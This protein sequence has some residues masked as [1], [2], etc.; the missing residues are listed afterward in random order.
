MPRPRFLHLA[1]VLFA[2]VLIIGLLAFVH[3][4]T[5]LPQIPTNLDLLGRQAGVRI[6]AD[7]G[8][9]LFT[10]DRRVDEVTLETVSPMFVNAV[11][12]TEDRDFY[13]HHGI[14]VKAILGAVYD[15]VR[16]L[17]RSRGGST[18]TQQIV[19]NLFLSREKTFTRKLKEALLAA[20]LETA[21]REDYGNVAKSRLLELYINGSFFGTN[22]YGVADA[23]RTYFGKSADSLSVREAAMLAG[24]PN[25]PGALSPFRDLEGA[26]RRTDHVLRRMATEGFL[27]QEDLVAAL[28]DSVQLA[29]ERLPRNR[30]PYFVETIK[31]EVARLWGRSAL[32]FGGLNIHTT[33]D[34]GMQ[35]AAEAAVSAGVADLDRR[36]G[37]P[38]YSSAS[39]AAR[40]SYVQSALI[41]LD[42]ATGGVR[43]MVGGRDIFVSYYNR[44]TTARRQPGS[45]FKPIVY[46]A[47]FASGDVTPVSLFVDEPR[48]YGSGRSA[49]RPENF[50][51][52]YLGLTT[53][54]WALINSANATAAQIVDRIGP[55]AVV[56]M[57]R[58]LGI[59]SPLAPYPSIALGSS[60][61]T[62][63][64]LVSA[65]GVIANYGLRVEP[66]FIRSIRALDGDEL[67]RHQA[68]PARM[69]DPEAA[70]T[71][72]RLMQN[73]IERGTGRTVRARGFASPAAGKTGT[74]NDN[75]DAWFTGFTPDLVT[76]VWVGFDTKGKGRKLIEKR[77]R[78][79]I[80]GASGA[81]PIW[82]AFMKSVADK[83]KPF[84]IPDGVSEVMVDPATGI[85]VLT[86]SLVSDSVVVQPIVIALPQGGR[87][88]SRDEVMDFRASLVP[89]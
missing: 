53:A 84:W 22:A 39:A 10:L 4:V 66:T 40:K 32:G 16:N 69:L 72:I 23:A 81:A 36:L 11:I 30:T 31:A 68:R 54:A 63:L 33:L 74:T 73:V 52:S 56:G 61:V 8:E 51:D 47:G 3:L 18:I 80:T 85:E 7:S 71:I 1:I 76:S 28:Q 12:A 82:T 9:L 64:E 25:A 5:T 35:Q 79:Q 20:Q 65:Y 75:T 60:E 48:S 34:F 77:S 86:D 17:R 19:K 21:F 49:W 14:S 70:F 62:P 24:L 57:A 2:D 50:K 38:D 87:P 83:G 6:Y 43:A 55:K 13:R 88:N 45:G 41:A 37:F 89:E 59:E 67:Y 27:A 29:D 78:R 58:R 42:P 15:N 46:L 44:A 26:R